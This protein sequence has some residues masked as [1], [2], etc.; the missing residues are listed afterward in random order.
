MNDEGTNRGYLRGSIRAG[1][2][3]TGEA[4]LKNRSIE[5]YGALAIFI[6]FTPFE[7]RRAA[8]ISVGVVVVPRSPSS[9]LLSLNVFFLFGFFPFLPLVFRAFL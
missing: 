3:A 2:K 6:R 8:S 1:K 9:S 7:R 5:I 4:F